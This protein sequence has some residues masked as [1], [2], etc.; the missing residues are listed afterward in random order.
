MMS[1]SAI[2]KR[3]REMSREAIAYREAARSVMLRYPGHAQ[4]ETRASERAS[5]LSTARD[6]EAR[7]QLAWWHFWNKPTLSKREACATPEA[8]AQELIKL[9]EWSSG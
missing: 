9:A 3:A 2:A 7:A 4:A 1:R 8:F 5:A 6:L